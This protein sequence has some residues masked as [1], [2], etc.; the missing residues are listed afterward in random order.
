MAGG[1]SSC[2]G[3]PDLMEAGGGEDDLSSTADFVKES[4]VV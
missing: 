3:S 1:C 2:E 4:I